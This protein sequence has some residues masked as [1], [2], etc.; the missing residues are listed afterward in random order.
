MNFVKILLLIARLQF[1][2]TIASNILIDIKI[3]AIIY[4]WDHASI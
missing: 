1:L 4:F 2:K 3:I